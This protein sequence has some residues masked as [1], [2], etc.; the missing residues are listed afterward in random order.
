ML[1]PS[2]LLYGFRL[3]FLPDAIPREGDQEH[4][5]SMSERFQYLSKVR[6]HFWN[7]WRRI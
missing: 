6:A 4:E 2:H 7:R 3:L 5:S 1:T